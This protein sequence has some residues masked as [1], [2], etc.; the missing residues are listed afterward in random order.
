MRRGWQLSDSGRRGWQFDGSGR[1][2]RLW[3]KRLDM[4]WVHQRI[5]SIWLLRLKLRRVVLRNDRR[6]R[7]FLLVHLRWNGF[8]GTMR[9][10]WQLSDSVWLRWSVRRRMGLGGMRK[11]ILASRLLLRR[12]RLVGLLLWNRRRE[13]LVCPLRRLWSWVGGMPSATSLIEQQCPGQRGLALHDPKFG[14]V[15]G[16]GNFINFSSIYIFSSAL[17]GFV[18]LISRIA[19]HSINLPSIL[20][21]FHHAFFTA[22]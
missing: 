6:L 3:L 15:L 9:R 7:R 12:M 21:T 19:L 18:S 5:H 22:L 16:Q 14:L 13:I 10:E 11:F 20:L 8:V 2:S 17:A 4:V 1:Q